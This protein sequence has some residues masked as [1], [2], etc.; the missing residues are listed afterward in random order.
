[1]S[2]T[3]FDQIGSNLQKAREQK[4]LTLSS[5]SKKCGIAESN[6]CNYE[7]GN[8]MSLKTFIKIVNALDVSFDSIL[9]GSKA[10][11][12]ENGKS[13]LTKENIANAI[14]YLFENQIIERKRVPEVSPNDM[15]AYTGND[16]YA[17]IEPSVLEASR[18]ASDSS[19][20][21]V[22]LFKYPYS[23]AVLRYISSLEKNINL[24]EKENEK[25][26]L[27]KVQKTILINELKNYKFKKNN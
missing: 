8:S 4:K 20:Y 24:V 5:L 12:F 22:V 14:E 16:I 18:F 11:Y 9:S 2:E 19:P 10:I 25:E 26:L 17:F 27:F 1:M 21:N 13:N 15:N 3:I 6:L 23:V 7:A